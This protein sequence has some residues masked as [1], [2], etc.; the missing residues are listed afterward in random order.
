MKDILKLLPFVALTFAVS[1]TSQAQ[2]ESSPTRPLYLPLVLPS[3]MPPPP[4]N[5]FENPGHIPSAHIIPHAQ[6]PEYPQED[7]PTPQELPRTPGSV[8]D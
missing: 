3:Q 6:P 5:Q 2:Q 7:L 4:Q 8:G 1:G